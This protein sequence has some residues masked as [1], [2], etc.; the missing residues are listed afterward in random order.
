[1]PE[2]HTPYLAAVT[3][4]APERW[5]LDPAEDPS[6]RRMKLKRNF[7]Y[8][9]YRGSADDAH[10][11][12]DDGRRLQRINSKLLAGATLFCAHSARALAHRPAPL[13]SAGYQGSP[14]GVWC[15]QI[16]TESRCLWC[17]A[18]LLH[19]GHVD[20]YM[21]ST[22]HDLFITGCLSPACSAVLLQ[23]G[24][25]HCSQLR[26]IAALTHKPVVLT[27]PQASRSS[28][29]PTSW[30]ATWTTWRR[31]RRPRPAP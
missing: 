31:P 24:L 8:R 12:E 7:K 19:L 3:S 25:E 28:A 27:A 14:L 18:T 6:R 1:M 13:A 5:K 29:A 30:T 17:A 11:P 9:H 21:H 16:C 2:T 4:G 22:N 10:P 15:L 20:C 26:H 23:A